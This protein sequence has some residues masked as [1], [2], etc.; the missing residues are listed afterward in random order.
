MVKNKFNEIMKGDL[1]YKPH[2]VRS[3][4]IMTTNGMSLVDSKVVAIA[5]GSKCICNM[6]VDDDGSVLHDMHAEVLARRCLIRFLYDQLDAMV[7]SKS[8]IYHLISDLTLL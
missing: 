6:N 4:I 2:K 1:K 5:T 7:D 8:M 3:A